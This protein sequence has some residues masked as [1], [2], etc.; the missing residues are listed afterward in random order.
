M[1]TKPWKSDIK[2]SYEKKVIR[3][4]KQ[5]IKTSQKLQSNYSSKKSHTFSLSLLIYN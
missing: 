3:N 1:W 2:I 5:I 4:T